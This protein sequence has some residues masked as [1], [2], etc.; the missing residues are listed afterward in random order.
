VKC[1]SVS[2]R[3]LALLALSRL[4]VLPQAL[5]RADTLSVGQQQHDAIARTLVQKPQIILADE[6][7][8]SLAPH[9]TA[10]VMA[11]LWA[12]NREDG[13]TVLCE[14]RAIDTAREIS[15]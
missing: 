15:K 12:I 9:N 4:D 8:A 10:R 1:F 14:R 6:P 5:Q 3:A 2:E 11:A 13:I 7:I